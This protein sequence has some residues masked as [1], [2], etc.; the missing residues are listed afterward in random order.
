M[1]CRD[2]PASPS[3]TRAILFAS[4][5]ALLVVG[6]S[7]GR[8]PVGQPS[9]PAAA[10][11]PR[12]APKLELY[13][14]VA[15]VRLRFRPDGD[16]WVGG[17]GSYTARVGAEGIRFTPRVSANDGG[18]A[19]AG[20][21]IVLG[22]PVVARGGVRG[23]AKAA[24]IVDEQKDLAIDRG[25]ATEALEN[26]EQGLV[27]SF[28]FEARP[29]GAGDVTVRIPV[30]G[31]RHDGAT[32][33]GLHFVDGAT[34]LGM[35]YGAA[36]WVDATGVRTP[37]AL[38]YDAGT[39]VLTVPAAVVDG[40]AYPAVL[41]PTLGPELGK[42]TPISTSSSE[43][44]GYQ[45]S[46]S[47]AGQ[48]LEV[49]CDVPPQ[50]E[51]GCAL[52]ATRVRAGSILDPYGIYLG[53]TPAAGKFALAFDDSSW[54]VSWEHSDAG[55]SALYGALVSAAG[56]AAPPG[57]YVNRMGPEGLRFFPLPKNGG[58]CPRAT[59]AVSAAA[60]AAS[61]APRR[62]TAVT[63]VTIKV[64]KRNHVVYVQIKH[65]NAHAADVLNRMFKAEAE[66]SAA[67]ILETALPDAT[68]VGDCRGGF[69]TEDVFWVECTGASMRDG[70][71][72]PFVYSQGRIWSLAGEEPSQLRLAEQFT[73]DWL[74]AAN[75]SCIADL[76]RRW[77]E[78]GVTSII[79]VETQ[80]WRPQ[81]EGLVL[82]F[83]AGELGLVN[84]GMPACTV[85]WGDIGCWVLPDSPLRPLADKAPPPPAAGP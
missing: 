42:D 59:A 25:L 2:P 53:Y 71:S 36:T 11:P 33:K 74:A 3:R 73:G 16:G 51:S 28:R 7:G 84:E 13:D 32:A 65:P 24:A 10:E 47:G 81:K 78:D 34:R 29:A 39:I 66:A 70:G 57:S 14:V 76:E 6:C 8:A 79:S 12:P 62:A 77:V 26:T 20:G 35:R 72:H 17:Q 4:F 38:A 31:L 82:T 49:W 5:A 23:A 9:A 85:P 19:Q 18:P 48:L 27:Q 80:T 22:A 75:T 54:L 56:V 1:P 50:G 44:E 45:S 43:A 61:R 60:P 67:H 15:R 83:Q 46:A 52:W 40:S 30:S 21:Q 68:V 63:P 64:S 69:A 55:R 37:V 41:D 58:R